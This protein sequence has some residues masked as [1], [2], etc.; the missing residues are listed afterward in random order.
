[1]WS[2]CPSCFALR[3][4]TLSPGLVAL[5]IRSLE[6]RLMLDKVIMVDKVRR[7]AILL[8]SHTS[9]GTLKMSFGIAEAFELRLR[10]S[11]HEHRLCRCECGLA[12]WVAGW[13]VGSSSGCLAG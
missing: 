6:D 10:R 12:G 2:V 5:I 7:W 13:L 3:F 1:M 9:L 4:L 8:L 11:I